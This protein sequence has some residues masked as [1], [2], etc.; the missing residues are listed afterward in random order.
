MPEQRLRAPLVAC[1]LLIGA[2]FRPQVA[3]LKFLFCYSG[4]IASTIEPE[5]QSRAPEWS[6]ILVNNQA[7]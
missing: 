2:C 7:R 4:G 5:S 1:T 3:K 6:S